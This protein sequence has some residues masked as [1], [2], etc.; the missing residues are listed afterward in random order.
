MQE[1]NL[2]T[3][4]QLKARYGNIS[5]MTLHRW[6]RDERMSFPQPLRINK[7]KYFSLSQIVEWEK[8]RATK[9]SA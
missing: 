6:E 5:D 2:I 1:D 3:S 9:A 4:A 7:R 8:R